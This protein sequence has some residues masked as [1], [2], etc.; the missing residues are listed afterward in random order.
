MEEGVGL[1]TFV[2][3]CVHNKIEADMQFKYYEDVCIH[4]Y[5]NVLRS[6]KFSKFRTIHTHAHTHICNDRNIEVMC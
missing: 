6:L 4:R 1:C 5:I 2:W 3:I